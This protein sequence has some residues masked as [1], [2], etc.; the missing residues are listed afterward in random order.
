MEILKQVKDIELE[1]YENIKSE[2]LPIYYGSTSYY[3][4]N[5]YYF[6]PAN[7]IQRDVLNNK[8]KGIV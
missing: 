3:N 8:I 4:K 2:I 5:K 1:M 6:V 7:C